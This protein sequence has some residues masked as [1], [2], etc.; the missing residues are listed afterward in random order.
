MPSCLIIDDEDKA[1]STISKLIALYQPELS[2]LGE[3][4]TVE[5]GIELIKRLNP[6]FVFLDIQIGSQTGFDLL[7]QID[8]TKIHVIFITAYSE[9]AIKAFELSALDYLVK[10]VDPERL[11]NAIEKGLKKEHPSTIERKYETLLKNLGQEPHIV[12][13]THDGIYSYQLDEIIRCE[14][15]GNYTHFLLND[16]TSLL[17]SSTLL[18]YEKRLKEHGFFRVH[19]KHLVNTKY[20][21]HTEKSPS[22]V[23]VLTNGSKV[24]LAWRRREELVSFIKATSI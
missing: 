16:G 17:V 11:S 3:A 21:R 18:E 4:S 1:R 23:V 20:F 2:V 13:S 7:E 12:L 14:A 8:Q 6:D 22:E 15:D 10:P 5:E 9:Y 19:K 24:P